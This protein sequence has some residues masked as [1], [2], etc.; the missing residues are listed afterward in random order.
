[1]KTIHRNTTTNTLSSL[2]FILM[3]LIISSM[4]A[5]CTLRIKTAFENKVPHKPGAPSPTSTHIAELEGISREARAAVG[6]GEPRTAGYWSILNSCAPDNRADVAAANGGR[7]AG[8]I[9]LDD[10]IENPGIHVGEYTVETCE[11][12][13]HFLQRDDQN[14]YPTHDPITR[15]AAQVLTAE[16]NLN[17]GSESCPIAEKAVLGGHL[18]LTKVGFNGP[19]EYGNSLSEGT[20]VALTP[21]LNLLRAYN[22]GDLCR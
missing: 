16:L 4:L 17:A 6:G 15:L 20:K 19:G 12:G 2:F 22:S 13:Y 11:D 1:M 14:G 8:W 5:S 7:G 21:V 3:T 10:L 18:L 9:L